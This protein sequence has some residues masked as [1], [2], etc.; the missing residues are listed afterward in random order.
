MSIIIAKQVKRRRIFLDSAETSN[1]LVKT[2]FA[3]NVVEQRHFTIQN[4]PFN[5]EFMITMMLERN[6]LTEF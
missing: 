3:E 6:T 1:R 5:P 2:I 4:M